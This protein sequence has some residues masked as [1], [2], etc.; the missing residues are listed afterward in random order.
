[1]NLELTAAAAAL[2]AEAGHRWP[3]KAYQVAC[4]RVRRQLLRASTTVN[5]PAAAQALRAEAA[6]YP[7]TGYTLRN[8]VR[9][10]LLDHAAL[11]V[12]DTSGSRWHQPGCGGCAAAQGVTR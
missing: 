4:R 11:Y 10:H 9:I 5:T 8:V 7:E 1:M 12:G 2:S 6:L 3:D